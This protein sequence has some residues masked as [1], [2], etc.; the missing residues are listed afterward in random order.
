MGYGD[1]STFYGYIVLNR[2]NLM[3]TAKYGRKLNV[4]A[5]GIVTGTNVGASIR[6]KTFDGTSMSA[7]RGG[8]VGVY[9]VSFHGVW[10]LII[11]L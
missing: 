10:M 7:N 9:N 2:I 8:E 5:Q 1:A 3:T 6:Y 4:L 11:I